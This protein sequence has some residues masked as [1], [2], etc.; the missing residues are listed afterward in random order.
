MAT[1]APTIGSP[2]TASVTV[3]PTVE[4]GVSGDGGT[5]KC[6]TGCASPASMVPA[7]QPMPRR[8]NVCQIWHTFALRGMGWYAGTIDAGDAHPVEH[9]KVPPSPETPRSTVGG[10]VTDA[11]TGEPIVGAVVAIT[12]HGSGFTGDYTAVT[13]AAGR[14]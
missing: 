7:Y 6:S 5:L 3:P 8:A 14:Y 4:R 2:V 9:F 1:T 12:G 13:N 11:V 10:T